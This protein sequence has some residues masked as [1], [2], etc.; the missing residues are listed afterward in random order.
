MIA[1][2]LIRA[3]IMQ[4]A[5]KKK[6]DPYR[7]SFKGTISTIRQWTP[8]MANLKNKHKKKTHKSNDE[9]IS[10]G[11]CTTQTQSLAT[12]SCEKKKK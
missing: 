10:N 2:N 9:N 11:S 12:K 6:I 1:Y 4:A 8:L 7:I 3:L 5:M